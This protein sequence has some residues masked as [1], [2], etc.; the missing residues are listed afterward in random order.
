MAEVFA[1]AMVL[2]DQGVE[3]ISEVLVGVGVSSIDSAMLIV[4]FNSTSN[5][6]IRKIIR[7]KFI[8]KICKNYCEKSCEIRR[9][10]KIELLSLSKY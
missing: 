5:G 2:K 9:V 8:K 6:L 4:I 3:H 10:N 1:Q 7:N